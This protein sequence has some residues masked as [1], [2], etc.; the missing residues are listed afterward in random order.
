[1]LQKNNDES[2]CTAEDIRRLRGPCMGDINPK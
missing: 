2:F 1:M